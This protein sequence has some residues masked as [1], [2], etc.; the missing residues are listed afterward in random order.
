MRSELYLQTAAVEQTCREIHSSGSAMHT[1]HT[2]EGQ[3]HSL[4]ACCNMHVYGSSSDSGVMSFLPP[5][6][7]HSPPPCHPPTHPCFSHP[8]HMRLPASGQPKI[9]GARPD[10]A[11]RIGIVTLELAATGTALAIAY[12]YS[13]AKK[14]LK[15]IPQDRIANDLVTAVKAF[16]THLPHTSSLRQYFEGVLLKADEDS[17][18]EP[19]PTFGGFPMGRPGHTFMSP[20]ADCGVADQSHIGHIWGCMLTGAALCG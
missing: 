2:A 5:C 19:D 13:R 14:V 20:H 7:R 3:A 15:L 9:A 16:L 8:G 18:A 6:S 17:E 11:G 1:M 10:L 12:A 4:C